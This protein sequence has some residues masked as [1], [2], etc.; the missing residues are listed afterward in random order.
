MRREFSRDDYDACVERIARQ[1]G[2]NEGTV[3]L[4][5]A[6]TAEAGSV[7][8]SAMTAGHP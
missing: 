2:S 3:E 7:E 1:F 8:N 4:R 5:N 6:R